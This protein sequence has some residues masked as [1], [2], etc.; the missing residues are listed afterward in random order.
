MSTNATHMVLVYAQFWKAK[1]LRCGTPN[2]KFTRAPEYRQNVVGVLA[3]VVGLLKCRQTLPHMVPVYAQ[4]W[5]TK[6]LR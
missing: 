2:R 5:K 4:F 3:D 1:A 6:A